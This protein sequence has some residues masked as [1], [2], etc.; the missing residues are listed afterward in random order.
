M[1]SVIAQLDE[2]ILSLDPRSIATAQKPVFVIN[3][4]QNFTFLILALSGASISLCA[5]LFTF[6][7][8]LQM[9]RRFRHQ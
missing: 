1:D 9:R 8:F 6:Y 5:G 3:E 7:W 4:S 2:E